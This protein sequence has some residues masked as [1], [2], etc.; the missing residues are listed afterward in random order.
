MRKKKKER[1]FSEQSGNRGCRLSKAEEASD[2]AE[3]KG[4][5]V[6]VTETFGLFIRSVDYKQN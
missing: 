3:E 1:R 2:A 6:S 5:L 4:L